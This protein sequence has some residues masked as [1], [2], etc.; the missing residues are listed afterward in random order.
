[1]E[2][3]RVSKKKAKKKVRKEIVANVDLRQTRLALLEDGKVAEFFI[4]RAEEKGIVG[5]IYKGRVETILPGIQAAFV[6]IGLERH[7]FL[8]VSDVLAEPLEEEEEMIAEEEQAV[9]PPR[10]REVAFSIEALLKPKQEVMVQVVKEPMGGKG[11]RLTTHISLPGR[12]LVLMPTVEHVGV[13]RKIESEKE[14]ERLKKLLIS[15]KPPGLGFIV[16]TAGEG[17]NQAEFLSDIKYLTGLWKKIQRRMESQPASSLLHEDIGQVLR[18]V[19]DIFTDDVDKFIVDNPVDYSRVLNFLDALSPHLK[20]KVELYKGQENIFDKYKIEEEIEKAL[21][22][23]V[24][25][26]SGGRL[27]IDITEAMVIVDVNTGKYKGKKSLEETVLKTNLEAAKEIARQL[28]LRDI[29]GIIVIDFIDMENP[30]HKARVIKALE[31]ALKIDRSKS[32]VSEMS[33][34]GLIQMTRKRVK[35]SLTQALSQPCPYCEGS[36]WVKSITTVS[37]QAIRELK[38]VCQNPQSPMSFCLKAHPEVAQRL[39][40]SEGDSLMTLEKKYGKKIEVKPMPDFHIE[41][42]QI[43]PSEDEAISPL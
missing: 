29:G 15:I 26:K 21:D 39:K 17:K 8:Y 24:W 18:V 28:R 27:G 42:V 11:T 22:R 41:E 6:D 3:S 5:N 40:Q 37:L 23:K 20:S 2:K 32:N 1:M 31:E 4:E 10:P 9:P 16:R 13:S 34:F 35:H 36:G 33:E 30:K 38:Q 19:R 25:L 7:G 12:F 43:L 14:R